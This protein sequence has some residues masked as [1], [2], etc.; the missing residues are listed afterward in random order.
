MS[1]FYD[2]V[3]PDAEAAAYSALMKQESVPYARQQSRMNGFHDGWAAARQADT[4]AGIKRI[5]DDQA[6]VAAL[7][8]LLYAQAVSDLIGG[9]PLQDAPQ[10][11]HLHPAHIGKWERRAKGLL[12]ALPGAQA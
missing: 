11:S 10:W 6:T 2:H 8:Q 3:T 5:K 9:D 1:T 7:A 12:E 4:D